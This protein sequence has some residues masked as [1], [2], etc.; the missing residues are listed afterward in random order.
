MKFS[1]RETGG[2]VLWSP[3]FIT[4]VA[5]VAA[6]IMWTLVVVVPVTRW[7]VEHPHYTGFIENMFFVV[8]TA[9]TS[10]IPVFVI[11]RIAMSAKIV[12]RDTGVDF[13][14]GFR[15]KHVPWEQIS[16]FY[17]TPLGMRVRQRNGEEMDVVTV[18]EF[19]WHRLPENTRQSVL[20]EL[21]AEQKQPA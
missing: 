10:F 14:N 6:G 15:T 9:V 13:V 3:S 21:A 20:E 12:V 5:A 7:A 4:R 18:P 2:R 8:S 17:P 1:G 11:I 16:E 19:M